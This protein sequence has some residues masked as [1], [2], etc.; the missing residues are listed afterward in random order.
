MAARPRLINPTA[1]A[2]ALALA[3]AVMVP[4]AARQ[5]VEAEVA[6]V[7]PAPATTPPTIPT[8]QIELAQ[9]EPIAGPGDR[10]RG[11]L[12]RRDGRG[13]GRSLSPDLIER[14]LE[15]ARDVDPA[16]ADRLESI[17]RERPPEEFARALREARHLV[18]LARLKDEDPALYDVKVN[19]LRLDAQVDLVLAELAEARR[20]MSPGAAD[21]EAQLYRLVRQQVGYSLI[22]RGMYLNR[23]NQQMKALRDQLEHDLAHNQQAVDRRIKQL[24]GELDEGAAPTTP[25]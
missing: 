19:E 3:A 17:R 23:L 12:G 25:N 16:L 11:R 21:L 13:S 9:A 5:D 15:V 24:L 1:L 22:A 2:V 8:E 14:C 18:S 20:T 7:S 6:P 10:L 4:T